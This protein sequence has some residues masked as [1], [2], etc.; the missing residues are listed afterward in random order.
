M[1][2]LRGQKNKGVA[3]GGAAKPASLGGH[4][5]GGDGDEARP[6]QLPQGLADG[7]FAAP[8]LLGDGADRGEADPLPVADAGEI[9]QNEFGPGADVHVEQVRPGIKGLSLFHDLAS[10]YLYTVYLAL[11][12]RASDNPFIFGRKKILKK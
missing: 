12:R 10:F 7:V 2:I 9:G 8:A 6:F 5:L 4:G 1:F 11:E 3:V